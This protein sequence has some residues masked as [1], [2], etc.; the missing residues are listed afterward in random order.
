PAVDGACRQKKRL[1]P[2]SA[3]TS[4]LTIVARAAGETR[5][6]AD[7]LFAECAKSYWQL[8]EELR[9]YTPY[10]SRPPLQTRCRKRI[11]RLVCSVQSK[12]RNQ[13]SRIKKLKRR[14]SAS[15]GRL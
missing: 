5:L 12:E 10:G 4:S 11:S 8:G 7:L 13:V 6:D 3:T 9:N 1:L 2:V 14:I 15:F